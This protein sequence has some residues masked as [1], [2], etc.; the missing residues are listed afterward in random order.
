MQP[1]DAKNK[2]TAIKQT[3]APTNTP[4]IK[5]F[6]ADLQL[7]NE[8]PEFHARDRA[9]SLLDSSRK[10]SDYIEIQKHVSGASSN[11]NKNMHNKLDDKRSFSPKERE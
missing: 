3:Q 5:R 10:N 6:Q 8:I 1:L 11:L 2:S 7:E 9:T 4:A